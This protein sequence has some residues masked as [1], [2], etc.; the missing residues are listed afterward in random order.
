MKALE[1]V[2]HDG[3]K[4][5]CRGEK[6]LETFVGNYRRLEGDRIKREFP[7]EQFLTHHIAVIEIDEKEY[8]TTPATTESAIYF[9]QGG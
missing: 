8:M 6:E 9:G 2:C 1:I 4:F 7:N 5:M 3:K